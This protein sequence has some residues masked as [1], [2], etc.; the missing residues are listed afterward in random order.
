M[1]KRLRKKDEKV[2]LDVHDISMSK[3]PETA[4]AGRALKS[5]MP[6]IISFSETEQDR[7]TD[8]D[9]FVIGISRTFAG[10]IVASFADRIDVLLEGDMMVESLANGIR[11]DMQKV[12]ELHKK[13][14]RRKR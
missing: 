9:T 5:F 8:L 1:R 7:G 2:L 14:A 12:L 3:D 6:T 4:C 11:A 10:M 13:E